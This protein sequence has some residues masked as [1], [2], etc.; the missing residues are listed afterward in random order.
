MTSR[1]GERST[2]NGQ[3]YIGM[4]Q[5]RYY[6]QM[7][8]YLIREATVADAEAIARVHVASWRE[9]YRG[10]IDDAIIDSRTI[11]RRTIQWTGALADRER[12]TFVACAKEAMCG[13][14]SAVVGEPSKPE[15]C[16][17]LQTLYVLRAAQGAGIGKALLQA[18]AEKLSLRGCTALRLHVLP[19]NSAARGFYEH[20]GAQYVGDLVATDNG[21]EWVD[22]VYE[23]KDLASLAAHEANK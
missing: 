8:A 20:L 3:F 23:W 7:A 9:T 10:L 6:R 4:Q 22:A 11:E 15:T 18:A 13:F 19:N 21:D 16:G 14:A 1:K 12:S 17:D 5:T 2:Y